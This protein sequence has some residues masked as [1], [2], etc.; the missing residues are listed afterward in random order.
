MS[1]K[2]FSPQQQQQ[3]RLPNLRQVADIF[4]LY[5]SQL[6]RSEHC[7]RKEDQQIIFLK[8]IEDISKLGTKYLDWKK[9]IEAKAGEY[10]MN[11]EKVSVDLELMRKFRPIVSDLFERKN[12]LKRNKETENMKKQRVNL[13]SKEKSLKI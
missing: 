12:D 13:Q 1:W 11:P 4:S 7:I 8:I 9:I 2:I 10:F 6:E 5:Y 3:A